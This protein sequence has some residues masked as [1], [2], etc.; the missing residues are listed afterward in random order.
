[1]V[2]T[3]SAARK[4]GGRRALVA[5]EAAFA[6]G[7]VVGASLIFGA[8]GLA[9]SALHP[10][11]VGVAVAAGLALAAAATDAA[12]RRVRPQIRF[13]VPEGWRRTMSLPRALFLYGVLLGTAA[14]PARRARPRRPLARPRHRGVRRRRRPRG[15]DR[16]HSGGRSERGRDRPRVAAA[17]RGRIPLAQRAGGATARHAPGGRRRAR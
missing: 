10:S 6:L 5:S 13:Q 3:V 8:L 14:G 16:G 7:L 4:L 15:D 17:G 9:G 11:R 12:G 2:G 1:M